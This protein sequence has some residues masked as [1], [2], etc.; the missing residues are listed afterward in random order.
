M[1]F[2]RNDFMW[3]F[4]I[5]GIIILL[6][7]IISSAV[8]YGKI[9]GISNDVTTKLDDTNRLLIELNSKILGLD[10]LNENIDEIKSDIYS[11]ESS[12]SILPNNT[13]SITNINTN[14]VEIN[15]NLDALKKAYPPNQTI[16]INNIKQEEL[17]SLINNVVDLEFSSISK[18]VQINFIFNIIFG[19]LLS[20]GGISFAIYYYNKKEK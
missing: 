10:K 1:T 15:N 7:L 3:I 19:S 2:S 16:V 11:I 8:I 14:L 17:N 13:A 12:I 20:L 5:I 18:K 6:A 4:V 9:V